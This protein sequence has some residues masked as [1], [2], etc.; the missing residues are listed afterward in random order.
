LTF[1]VTGIGARPPSKTFVIKNLSKTNPLI[2]T[3]A[4]PNS[5]FFINPTGAFA[6]LPKKSL[7]VEVSFNP[8]DAMTYSVPLAIDSND[9]AH[10]EVDVTLSGTGESGV[11]AAPSTVT[12]AATKV[13]KSATKRVSI[14][15]SGKGVLSGS[16]PSLG[17]AFSASPTGPFTLNP[18]KS[19]TLTLKFQ[20]EFTGEIESQVTIFVSP[21][22]QPAEPEIELLGTGK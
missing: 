5:A 4:Q 20:P 1:A 8:A 9:P 3:I 12:F 22:S 6:V 7:K 16:I 10:P 14:R 21:P 18:A 17:G 2:G 11:L 19:L 13:G 15:N